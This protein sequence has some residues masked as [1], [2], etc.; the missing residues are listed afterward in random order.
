MKQYLIRTQYGLWRILHSRGCLCYYDIHNGILGERRLFMAGAEPDFAL[1]HHDGQ[2]HVIYQNKHGEILYA[3][4]GSPLTAQG[5]PVWQ[6]ETLLVPAKKGYYDKGFE[7]VAYNGVLRMFYL[8]RHEGKRLLITDT[9]QQSEPQAIDYVLRYTPC[10]APDGILLYLER[11]DGVGIRRVAGSIG[12]FVAT[13]GLPALSEPRLCTDN[14][15]HIAGCDG[16]E[17]HYYALT[18]EMDLRA[19]AL[20]IVRHDRIGVGRAPLIAPYATQRTMEA[21]AFDDLTEDE[22]VG[23]NTDRAYRIS[24]VPPRSSTLAVYDTTSRRPRY[25]GLPIRAMPQILHDGD[26]WV[27]G[28]TSGNAIQVIKQ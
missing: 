22:V 18:R 24:Y 21:D 16:G 25:I 5:D 3:R 10:N 17:V 26:A 14:L 15:L 19:A 9:P 23:Y 4:G 2:L 8:I 27:Y 28:Y 13:D 12:P 6:T 20:R 1:L 11:A 7:L